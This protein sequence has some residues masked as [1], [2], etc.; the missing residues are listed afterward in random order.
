MATTA[1]EPSL[2]NLNSVES[3]KKKAAATQNAMEKKRAS[4]DPR[5]RYILEKF[6]TFIDEKPATLENSL[7]LGSKLDILNDFFAEGGCRKV[8]LFWQKVRV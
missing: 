8:L 2:T 7:L 6:G 3:D 4:L 1:K 5:H